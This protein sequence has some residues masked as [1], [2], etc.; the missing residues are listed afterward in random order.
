MAKTGTAGHV[1]GCGYVGAVHIRQV[2]SPHQAGGQSTSDRRAVYIGQAGRG[3]DAVLDHA[4]A[5]VGKHAGIQRFPGAG[6]GR[7][8]IQALG[9]D[10]TTVNWGLLINLQSFYVHAAGVTVGH[11]LVPAVHQQPS[12][13][14]GRQ[15]V[16]PRAHR[17]GCDN[18]IA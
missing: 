9:I 17:H 2:G 10:L 7:I 8:D 16:G 12:A 1:D 5:A 11:V 4:Q 15:R 3:S 14:G 13:I 6:A 18:V